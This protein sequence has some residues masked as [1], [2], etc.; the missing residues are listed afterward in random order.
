MN[1]RKLLYY[2]VH[3]PIQTQQPIINQVDNNNHVKKIRVIIERGMF[4]KTT[5]T[6][7]AHLDTL[8]PL[9]S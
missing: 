1:W 2:I 9:Y 3:C 6:Y 8:K 7:F 4:Y 5:C